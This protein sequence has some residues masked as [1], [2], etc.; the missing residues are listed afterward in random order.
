MQEKK[1]AEDF[2]IDEELSK[3]SRIHGNENIITKI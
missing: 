1:P 3:L 2:E